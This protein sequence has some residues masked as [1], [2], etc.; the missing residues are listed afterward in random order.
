MKANKKKNYSVART[1]TELAETLGLTPAEAVLME[2][3][4]Q[5][6]KMATKAIEQ[7]E[8]TVNEIVKRSGIARSKVSAIK[9]GAIIYRSL[10][11]GHLGNRS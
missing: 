1:P 2:H 11:E 10:R 7:S 8:L 5:L 4:A 9:N 3:K 6:S